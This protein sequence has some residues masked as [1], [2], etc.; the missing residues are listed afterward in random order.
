VEP[1][2]RDW[3]HLTW[4]GRAVMLWYPIRHRF[5]APAPAAMRCIMGYPI[6][7]HVRCPRAVIEDDGL[8]C[9]RHMPTE[10]RP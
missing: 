10:R 9:R 3:L 7:E 8:W 5:V 4:S 2:I 1:V 6:G